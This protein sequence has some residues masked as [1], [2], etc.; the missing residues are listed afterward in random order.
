MRLWHYRI[1]S[2]LPR[3]QLI[4]QLRE[5]V[6]IGKNLF[7]KGTPNH[8]IVNRV[9]PFYPNDYAKYCKL[10]VDEIRG[11][12]YN[13]SSKT[14][15]KLSVY[16]KTDI[17]ALVVSKDE[18]IFPGFHTNRYFRQCYYNLQEKYDDGI[19]PEKEWKTLDEA[20]WK[21]LAM[22]GD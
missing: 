12:G 8:I 16:C 17:E 18:A 22:H 13:V 2:V 15:K 4:S 9:I 19:V 20:C 6:L 3:K 10:L 1:L 5:C 7:E 21:N 14:I 11:R